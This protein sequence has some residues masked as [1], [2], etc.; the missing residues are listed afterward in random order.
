MNRIPF[1]RKK[2]VEGKS[3]MILIRIDIFGLFFIEEKSRKIKAND[4]DANA[5]KEFAVSL[6]FSN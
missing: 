6:S 3:K 2:K 1:L 5:A 4:S